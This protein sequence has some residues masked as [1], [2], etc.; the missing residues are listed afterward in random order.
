M[1]STAPMTLV[2]YCFG[3]GGLVSL[4]LLAGMVM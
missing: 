2:L 1:N 4:V 3:L